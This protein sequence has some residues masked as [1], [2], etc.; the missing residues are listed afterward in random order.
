MGLV[1]VWEFVFLFC[2]R[3]GKGESE[4]PERGGGFFNEKSQE[5]G[6]VSG[7]VGGGGDGL[8]GCL[9]GIWGGGA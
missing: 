7:W 6:E 3:E 8:G 5:G 4:A 2:S 1:D 9:Q